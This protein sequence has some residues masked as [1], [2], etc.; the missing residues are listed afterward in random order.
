M[1]LQEQIKQI[2][3]LLVEQ[4]TP[5]ENNIIDELSDILKTWETKDYPSAEVRYEAY[6]RD[7]QN[8]VNRTLKK[9]P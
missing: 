1:E 2:K 5:A 8:L 4:G 6:Y 3:R 7:I 9:Q